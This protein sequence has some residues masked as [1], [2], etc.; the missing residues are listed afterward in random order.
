VKIEYSGVRVLD[1]EQLEL[2]SPLAGAAQ[3][4]DSLLGAELQRLDSLYFNAGY[5]G[6]VI[7]ADT[8]RI[9]DGLLVDISVRE[10]EQAGLGRISFAGANPAGPEGGIYELENRERFSPQAVG[11]AMSQTLGSLNRAG[12]PYAQVWISGFVYRSGDNVVDIS[13]SVVSGEE[14]TVD[15]ILF[16]GIS[17]TDTSTA[18]IASGF[19]RGRRYD[20]RML[21]RIRSRLEASGLFAGVGRARVVRRQSGGVALVFPVEELVN[22][23][24]FRGAFGFSRKDNDE[25]EVN[26]NVELQLD[27]IAGTGRRAEFAWINDGRDYSRTA[28]SY[29]EPFLFSRN[30]SLE[31]SLRQVV[32][33]SLY[34]MSSGSL[35]FRAPLGPAGF[36]LALSASADRNVLQYSTDLSRSFRQR[37]GIG[38][39]KKSGTYL[40]FESSLEGALKKNYYR[41]RDDQSLW[42]LLYNFE[43]STEVPTFRGQSV[44]LRTVSE[45]IF[46]GGEIHPAELFPV[47]GARS[48]RGYRENQFRAERVS[49]LNLEYRL[50]DISRVFLFGDAGLL[51]RGD[52]GWQVRNGA[53]FGIRSVSA[54]G[55]IE[56][57]FG[58]AERFSLD[59]AR[60]HVSLVESF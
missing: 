6:A 51:Y 38:I 22:R 48:I 55:I 32:Q 31:G 17:S 42:Q 12:Y 52:N 41:S 45:G 16:E 44:Y 18:L 46:S 43:V 23:N 40:R 14:M 25:Y 24:R 29:L 26:G 1:S 50:G 56:L 20:E 59:A 7:N 54:V 30:L 8:A 53:G 13:F 4:S 57:S 3:Y 37:Y 21:D 11:R 28:V 39:E 15:E 10:G 19:S 5:P 49:Y 9:S 35:K 34:N 27:N 33:D 60:I 36:R 47:G 2:S 58:V